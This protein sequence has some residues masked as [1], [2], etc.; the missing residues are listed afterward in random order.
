MSRDKVNEA[1]EAMK[2]QIMSE[3]VLMPASLVWSGSID[4]L[5][6]GRS[7]S[8]E[9]RR[10]I[11]QQLVDSGW[12]LRSGRGWILTITQTGDADA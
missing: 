12:L 11:F 3:A 8:R 6:V 2:D 1:R 10:Q 4:S 9:R 5:D 7:M